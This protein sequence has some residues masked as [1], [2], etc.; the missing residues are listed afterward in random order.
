MIQAIPNRIIIIAASC[1][2][3]LSGF[4]AVK[5]LTTIKTEEK[6]MQMVFRVLF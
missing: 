2:N 1:I 3:S 6:I 5:I 4:L